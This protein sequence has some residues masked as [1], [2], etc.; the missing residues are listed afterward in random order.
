VA[1]TGL[2]TACT[3]WVGIGAC[4]TVIAGIYLFGE[5]RHPLRL[6]GVLLIVARIVGLRLLEP[7]VPAASGDGGPD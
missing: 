3:V 4:G 6:A 7:G 5:T 1:A 2:G